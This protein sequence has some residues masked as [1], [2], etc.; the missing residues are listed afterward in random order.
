MQDSN[1]KSNW[2][3]IAAEM[4][5][6]RDDQRQLRWGV[7]DIV[8]AFYLA[9]LCTP[10]ERLRVEQALAADHE[11]AEALDL[12]RSAF[13]QQ[14]T[15]TIREAVGTLGQRLQVWLDR[16]GHC[17]AAGLETLRQA[18]AALSAASLSDADAADRPTWKIPVSDVNYEITV[19][20]APPSSV[21]DRE[22]LLWFQL[23]GSN[24]ALGEASIKLA[25]PNAFPTVMGKAQDFQAKWL[26]LEEGD[27]LFTLQVERDVRAIPV[28][29][30]LPERP[31]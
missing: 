23:S 19:R 2:D 10:E 16:A 22:W 13:A 8:L 21:T 27:W 24:P 25:R 28:V 11:L 18:P 29:L 3:R 4:R 12:M 1:A 5:A 31:S 20:I 7:D 30:G 6:Y 17:I 9:N 26:R 14:Q 15:W